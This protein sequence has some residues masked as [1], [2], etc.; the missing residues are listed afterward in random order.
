MSLWNA[1]HNRA[2]IRHFSVYRH[3]LLPVKQLSAH[4]KELNYIYI[5]Q[6]GFRRGHS[7]AQAIGQV[8][9]WVLESMDKGKITG[10]FFVDI[11][12]AF[13]S[14]NHKVLLG[15]LANMPYG[16][17]LYEQHSQELCSTPAKSKLAADNFQPTVCHRLCIT[18]CSCNFPQ[19]RNYPI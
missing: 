15:K 10:L 2:R 16:T 4:L 5:H 1:K 17:F 8:N 7:T 11:S 12:K 19:G 9:N 3:A 18:G 14:I 6:Y 13:D